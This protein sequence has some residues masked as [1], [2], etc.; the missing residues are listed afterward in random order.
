MFFVLFAS[1]HGQKRDKEAFTLMRKITKYDAEGLKY[2]SITKKDSIALKTCYYT[3][4]GDFES[5]YSMRVWAQAYVC[6]HAHG[7]V[8]MYNIRSFALSI[9]LKC[10]YVL[11]S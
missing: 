7:V 1:A 8:C 10:E 3:R 9:A 11:K 4:K 5:Y 6:A 2:V